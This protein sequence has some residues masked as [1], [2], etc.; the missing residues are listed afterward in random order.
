MLLLALGVSTQ[1]PLSAAALAVVVPGAVTLVGAG[2]RLIGWFGGSAGLTRIACQ[3]DGRW[4]LTDGSGRTMDAE[5]A[6]GSRITSFALWLEWRGRVGRPLL[7][8]PGDV[9]AEDFRR[10]VV[11]LRLS[12]TP[13]TRSTP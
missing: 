2:F 9:P 4:A 7:L 12:A 5:L 6:A 10:L 3:P 8:L 11:R 1:L 13:E